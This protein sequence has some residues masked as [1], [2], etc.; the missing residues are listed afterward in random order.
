MSA[1]EQLRRSPSRAGANRDAFADG[2]CGL[3]QRGF[4]GMSVA[5]SVVAE[6]AARLTSA[7]AER[8]RATVDLAPRTLHRGRLRVGAW[9]A[10]QFSADH[11]TET[12]AVHVYR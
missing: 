4:G 1:W 2:R 12:E 3:N 6:P 9:L 8:Y 5:D 11:F 10:R 7:V